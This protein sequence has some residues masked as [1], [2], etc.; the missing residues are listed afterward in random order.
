M[1]ALIVI[2]LFIGLPILL[3]FLFRINAVTLLLSLCAGD[4][5]QRFTGNDAATIFGSFS[6]QGHEGASQFSQ[7]ILLLLPAL[8]VLLFLRKSVARSKSLINLI[9]AIAAGAVAGIL[10][11]PLLPGGVRYNVVQSTYWMHVNQYQSTIVAGS[12]LVA[13][14]MLWLI[15][16]RP[17]KD[18]KRK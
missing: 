1:L 14:I 6:S 2:G 12:I 5:L 7:L 9:P 16:P 13:F 17:D 4:V 11:V 3:T 18:K 8:F 15:H 10:A